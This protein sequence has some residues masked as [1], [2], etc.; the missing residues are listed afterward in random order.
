MGNVLLFFAQAQYLR[1][2]IYLNFSPRTSTALPFIISLVTAFV[3]LFAEVVNFDVA[4]AENAA[5]VLTTDIAF[6]MRFASIST[7]ESSKRIEMLQCAFSSDGLC[8]PPKQRHEIRSKLCISRALRIACRL[9]CHFQ[10]QE[11]ADSHNVIA[12]STRDV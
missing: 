2:K 9:D 10:S 11:V 6:R 1:R 8:V 4:L 7:S 3:T 5:L 12:K